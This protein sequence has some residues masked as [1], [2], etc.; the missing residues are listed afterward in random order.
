MRSQLQLASPSKYLMQW[1]PA[2]S[3]Q[4]SN[5][6]HRTSCTAVKDFVSASQER[7]KSRGGFGRHC[8][9]TACRCQGACMHACN[10]SKC[11]HFS[12][13]STLHAHSR[14]HNCIVLRTP[15]SAP[16]M[17]S[18]MPSCT[19]GPTD[20]GSSQSGRRCTICAGVT[21][22]RRRRGRL[23]WWPLWRWCPKLLQ[24]RAGESFNLSC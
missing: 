11:Q 21:L 10:I 3:G 8:W 7:S 13:S 24:S 4:Q 1:I 22:W 9:K 12:S 2:I 23:P 6:R 18:H 16:Q 14:I 5:E 15:H 20:P 19:G 17:T